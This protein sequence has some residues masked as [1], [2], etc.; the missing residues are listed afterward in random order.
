M[1]TRAEITGRKEALLN[2]LRSIHSSGRFR[3]G[4]P[5]PSVRELGEKFNLSTRIISQELEVLVNEGVLNK[6]PNVGT[7]F[8]RPRNDAFEFYLLV[9]PREIGEYGGSRD[10]YISLQNGFDERIAQLGGTSLTMTQEQALAARGRGELPPIAGVANFGQSAVNRG[11][12]HIEGVPQVCFED[13]VEAPDVSDVVGFDN[14]SGG[15]LATEHLLHQ[16]H[17]RIAFL[18]AHH[19]TIAEF[20]WSARRENGWRTKMNEA[21]LATEGL[22]LG[23]N[24]EQARRAA[25]N[26][27]SQHLIAQEVIASYVGPRGIEVA[28]ER[29]SA[30]VTYNDAAA[31]HVLIALRE[32]RVPHQFWPAI[33]GFDNAP[34]AS[35]HVLTSLRLPWEEIGR[36]AAELMWARRHG[37]LTGAPTYREV[38][39][40]LIPR[41]TCRNDWSQHPEHAALAIAA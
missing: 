24:A 9:L 10:F 41:L 22:V 18:S 7:F 15:R 19:P 27:L 36:H 20:A 21:G 6:V 2:E 4:S 29:V 5:V 32:A 39:M 16:G 17:E 38:S 8:G 11:W 30:I 14:E 28:G 25:L 23:R 13:M 3:A 34:G 1:A 31:I 37:E 12:G 26:P 40:R 33:V 35:G